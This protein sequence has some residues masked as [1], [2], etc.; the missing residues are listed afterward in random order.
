MALGQGRF[1]EKCQV[2]LQAWGCTANHP[3]T[4]YFRPRNYNPVSKPLESLLPGEP[5]GLQH[6]TTNLH[7]EGGNQSYPG[8]CPPPG[9]LGIPDTDLLLQQISRVRAEESMML[10]AFTASGKLPWASLTP[11]INDSANRK[12]LRCGWNDPLE[13]AFTL[14]NCWCWGQPLL[15]A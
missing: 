11:E 4:P 8:P 15:G 14:R 1:Q 2:P 13:S 9:P 10:R 12:P 6:P 5:R 3:T 7:C